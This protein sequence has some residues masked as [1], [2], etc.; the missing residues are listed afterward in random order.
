MST[1]N[2]GTL[3]YSNPNGSSIEFTNAAPFVIT[4]SVVMAPIPETVR[5]N[6]AGGTWAGSM[7]TEPECVEQPCIPFNTTL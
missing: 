4:P 5:R 3:Y 6:G 2:N 1:L 7:N